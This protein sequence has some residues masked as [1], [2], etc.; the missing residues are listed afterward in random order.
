MRANRRGTSA[1]TTPR[2]F[3]I[4]LRITFL[5]Q[6]KPLVALLRPRRGT[7]QGRPRRSR[8][9][10]MRPGRPTTIG[11]CGAC[12]APAAVP[13]LPPRSAR[14][15]LAGNSP[16]I[17]QTV[18]AQGLEAAREGSVC[19]MFHCSVKY[20]TYVMAP[21]ASPREREYHHKGVSFPAGTPEQRNAD[22]QRAAEPRERPG[23]QQRAAHPASTPQTSTHE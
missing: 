23:G 11:G 5:A 8:T 2:L 15:G 10:A 22:P 3:E 16:R 18:G 6:K 1:S 9:L 19:T 20:Y 14:K 13:L 12:Q 7:P 21:P 17:P 4:A